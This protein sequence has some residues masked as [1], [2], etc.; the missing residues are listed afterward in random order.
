MAG[1]LQQLMVES[2]DESRASRGSLQTTVAMSALASFLSYLTFAAGGSPQ[3]QRE[4]TQA[5]LVRIH[6]NLFL[7]P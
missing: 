2:M 4:C 1:R 3:P 6:I 5:Q 7:V